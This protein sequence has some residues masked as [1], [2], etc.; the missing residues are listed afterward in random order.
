M[1][2]AQREALRRERRTANAAGRT[3][4]RRLGPA[5]RPEI[6]C[7]HFIPRDPPRRESFLENILRLFSWGRL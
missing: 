5:M 6:I 4:N 2:K 7:I 1:K 3:E